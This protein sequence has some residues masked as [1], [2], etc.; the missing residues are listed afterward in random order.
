M[1]IDRVRQSDF[2]IHHM[3]INAHGVLRECRIARFSK[4]NF[5]ASGQA[6]RLAELRYLGGSNCAASPS[7]LDCLWRSR[8]WPLITGPTDQ[9]LS[10]KDPQKI[11][12]SEVF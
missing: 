7:R 9:G 5:A 3:S 4:S 8:F 6:R 10:Y 12:S 1:R 11:R 2:P